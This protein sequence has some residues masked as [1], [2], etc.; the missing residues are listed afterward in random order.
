VRR[1][2]APDL[3]MPWVAIESFENTIAS[4]VLARPGLGAAVHGVLV[5]SLRANS[6]AIAIIAATIGITLPPWGLSFIQSYAVDKKVRTDDLP[7]ERVDVV[8]GAVLTG[9]IGFFVVVACAA[10]LHR[11]MTIADC[12]GTFGPITRG[13]LTAIL[14]LR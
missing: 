13:C 14:T 10:T 6:A 11:P 9:I 2:R 5:P 12:V 3:L 4:G 7:L 8:T 1:H